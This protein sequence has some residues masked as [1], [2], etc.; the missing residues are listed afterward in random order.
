MR[1]SFFLIGLVLSSLVITMFS[2]FA[3][4]LTGTYGVT[5]DNTTLEDYNQLLLLEN[6]TKSIES[7][8]I[9]NETIDTSALDVLG[10]ILTGVKDTLSLA[11]SSFGVFETMSNNALEDMGI[12]SGSSTNNVKKDL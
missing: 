8:V 4:D 6:K 12:S 3:T 10:G 7:S 1:I 11:W 9:G 2:L 5:I